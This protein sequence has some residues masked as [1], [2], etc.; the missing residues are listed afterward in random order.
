MARNLQTRSAET[1]FVINASFVYSRGTWH[2][3]QSVGLDPSI[4]K[5]SDEVDSCW[6]SPIS[7]TSQILSA[8]SYRAASS[9]HCC[10]YYSSTTRATSEQLCDARCKCKLYADDVKLYASFSL[11]D[12]D[13]SVIQNKFDAA[14]SWAD[15]WQLKISYAKCNVLIVGRDRLPAPCLHINGLAIASTIAVCATLAYWRSETCRFQSLCKA[16]ARVNLVFKCFLSRDIVTLVR[17]YTT[18]VRPL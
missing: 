4:F 7:P 11:S 9:A 6:A 8:E 18:Y 5:W 10:F 2:Q 14:H 3:W 1:Y 17:A 15:R 16:F 12:T 13:Y